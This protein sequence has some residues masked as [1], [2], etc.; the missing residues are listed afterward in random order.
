MG[1]PHP[2]IIFNINNYDIN[3]EQECIPVGCVLPALDLT[4]P[5]YWTETPH[6]TETPPPDRDPLDRD[7]PWIETPHQTE[8][9]Q[10]EIPL[11]RG[12]TNTCEN[13]TF[14]NF[15]CER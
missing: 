10:T 12:Q 3:Y 2:L 4:R 15:V 9:P 6:Q 7:P 8:T 14:A 5:S 11:P 1:D 13:I